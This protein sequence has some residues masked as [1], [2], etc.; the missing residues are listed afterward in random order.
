MA[1]RPGKDSSQLQPAR[2]KLQPARTTLQ[3]ARKMSLHMSFGV[4]QALYTHMYIHTYIH[5]YL[6]TYIHTYTHTHIHTYIHNQACLYNT[7]RVRASTYCERHLYI[8]IGTQRVLRIHTFG[9]F[10]HL[11]GLGNP[12]VSFV[13]RQL[14]GSKAQFRP[15]F[16][17][18]FQVRRSQLRIEDVLKKL[19]RNQRSK[20][21][22]EPS[23]TQE[24]RRTSIRWTGLPG[25]FQ[26]YRTR[27]LTT[28]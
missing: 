1:G 23:K 11:S 19:S 28:I 25:W 21:E 18:P 7:D 12:L 5:T 2:K 24:L 3:P 16:Q 20:L 9:Q 4:S 15:G 6:N 14:G 8:Y 22:R 13:Q 26:T 10:K 27:A 17:G